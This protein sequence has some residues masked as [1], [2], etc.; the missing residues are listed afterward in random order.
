MS[1]PSWFSEILRPLKGPCSVCC[2]DKMEHIQMVK[3]SMDTIIFKPQESYS[4]Q[5]I[6]QLKKKY[7]PLCVW[8]RRLRAQIRRFAF[9]PV[10]FDPSKPCS[11]QLCHPSHEYDFA[12]VC[13]KCRT[14]HQET[15]QKLY[16]QV[17]QIKIGF[18]SCQT[19]QKKITK[20]NSNCFDFDHLDPIQ[21]CEPI[22]DMVAQLFPIDIIHHE[23]SKCRLLCC[24]CHATH[25]RQQR[26]IIFGKE[27][28]SLR[29]LMREKTTGRRRVDAY[30][31]KE[32]IIKDHV[33][34]T[35]YITQKARQR[36]ARIEKKRREKE[37]RKHDR[38]K[39]L[40]EKKRQKEKQKEKEKQERLQRYEVN[41]REREKRKIERVE[42]IE[43]KKYMTAKEE[44][45]KFQELVKLLGPIEP[46][47]CEISFE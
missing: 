4:A 26:P 23:I 7:V 45:R 46:P 24:Y 42:R 13:L 25:T 10:Q 47:E 19:C 39:L 17:Q 41:M 16:K 43:M 37:K 38:L 30:H 1:K 34:G 11:G 12:Q 27:L 36:Q 21:K 2:H 9:R 22:S 29:T 32:Q 15:V 18:Q 6:E 20:V 35:I 31:I 8:C 28:R 3:D 40:E 33:P 5:Q 44:E 14:H